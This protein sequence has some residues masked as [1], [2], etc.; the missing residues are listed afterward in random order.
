MISNDHMTLVK[1]QGFS[2]MKVN[3]TLEAG[4]HRMLAAWRSVDLSSPAYPSPL[5]P[6]PYQPGHKDRG[7]E[8]HLLKKRG[9]CGCLFSHR[10]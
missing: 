4:G 5:S 9:F 2:G 7:K 1:V 6:S 3:T 8:W 10:G